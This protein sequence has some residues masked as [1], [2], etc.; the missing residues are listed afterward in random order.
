MTFLLPRLTLKLSAY[1]YTF[2]QKEGAICHS[3]ISSTSGRATSVAFT[4][5]GF[6]RGPYFTMVPDDNF[7]LAFDFVLRYLTNLQK[8]K[9]S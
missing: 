7:A 9:K 2:G 6:S 5:T 3:R 1:F 8:D 4:K